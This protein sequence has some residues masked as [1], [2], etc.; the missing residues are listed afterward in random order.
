VHFVF[1]HR[2]DLAALMLPYKL[3]TAAAISTRSTLRSMQGFAADHARQ[4]Y[5]TEP[6]FQDRHA[7]IANDVK[8]VPYIAKHCIVLGCASDNHI[9]TDCDGGCGNNEEKREIEPPSSLSERNI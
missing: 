1:R 9:A 7:S 2:H 6:P 4:Q 5:Q 3:T 8:P